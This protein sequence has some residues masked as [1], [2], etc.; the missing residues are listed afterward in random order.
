MANGFIVIFVNGRRSHNYGVRPTLKEAFDLARYIYSLH[1]R[2][3]DCHVEIVNRIT[4]EVTV[5]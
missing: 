3:Y 5:W 4:G 1:P 2:R